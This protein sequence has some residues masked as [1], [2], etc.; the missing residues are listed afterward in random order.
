MICGGSKAEVTSTISSIFMELNVGF[1]TT[2]H[3]FKT[4]TVK[5][6]MKTNV[7]TV[8]FLF[9]MMQSE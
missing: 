8:M 6:K 4:L 7:F 5:V 1:H 2:K 3:R 9:A